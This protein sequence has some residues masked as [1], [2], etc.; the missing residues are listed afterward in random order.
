MNLHDFLFA[1][2]IL[3]A[4]TTVTVAIFKRIGLGSVL[5]LLA[6]GVVVGPWGFA[7]TDDVSELRH[8]AE[9]G[10]V[11]LLFIIGLEMR[12]EKLWSMRR[13]VFGLGTAQVV[14]TGVLL[15][16][17]VSLTGASTSVAI[18]VGFGLALSST[19]FVLQIL[20]ERGELPTEH[21]QNTFAILLLQD[22]AIVPLLALV[23]LLAESAP[24]SNETP[25][26]LT[27]LMIVGALA[28]LFVFGRYVLPHVLHR[29]AATRNRDGFAVATMLSVIGAAWLMDDLGVSMAL[30]AFVMGMLLS[31]SDYRHQ[32]EAVVDPFKGF[33][34]GL[35]FIS[36]GMSIDV[37]LI[38]DNAATAIASVFAV[39]VCK[40]LVLIAVGKAF[41]L[42]N[43]IAIR[44]AL[45]LPQCGEFGFVLFGAAVSANLLTA[46]LFNY[47]ILVISVSMI[48]TPLLAKLGDRLASGLAK[49]PEAADPGRSTP[50]RR[51]AAMPLSAVSAASDARSVFCF[52]PSACPMS[53]WTATPSA[54]PSASR[55]GIR[56]ILAM[57]PTKP[58]CRRWAWRGR[59]ASC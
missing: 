50:V 39:L 51:R 17:L 49:K 56:C 16:I 26:G 1:A 11:F 37:G 42:R 29:F 10:V 27:I 18:I 40:F 34:L 48:C 12:P 13:S 28:G 22:I 45:Y 4:A 58:S 31:G 54:S 15:G 2:A 46:D 8:F 25:V 57:L 30:G 9:I 53:P 44:V 5:G 47:L 36:V 33:L 21:G 38:V 59:H 23:P 35:F 6:A 14:V 55:R 52:A 43:E 20:S 19:A 41:G 3:L 24:D 7:V 32:I